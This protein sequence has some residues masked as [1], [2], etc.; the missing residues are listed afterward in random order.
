MLTEYALLKL[1]AINGE[2]QFVH[3]LPALIGSKRTRDLRP[4]AQ[5]DHPLEVLPI[6]NIIDTFHY[7]ALIYYQ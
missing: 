7:H 1:Q 5:L 4:S 2:E 3:T 6:T